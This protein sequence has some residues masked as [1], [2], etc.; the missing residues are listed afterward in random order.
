MQIYKYM[1]HFYIVFFMRSNLLYIETTNYEQNMKVKSRNN[2]KGQFRSHD[3]NES[4]CSRLYTVF[5]MLSKILRLI[6][7]EKREIVKS[8]FVNAYSDVNNKLGRF[9]E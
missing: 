2:L 3:A 5:Y 7:I 9:I 6:I 8:S 1:S 4:M